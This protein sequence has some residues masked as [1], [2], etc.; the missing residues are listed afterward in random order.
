MR[1][2]R[3]WS[4]TRIEQEAE[5]ITQPTLLV[6][7]AHDREVPLKSGERLHELIKGSRLFVFPNCGHLP[8]EERPQEFAALVSEFCRDEGTVAA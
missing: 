3:S 5:R 8:Q 6:W 2:L 4:A 1:T 7:G